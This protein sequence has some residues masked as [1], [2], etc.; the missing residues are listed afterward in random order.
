MPL[1]RHDCP[2]SATI[3]HRLSTLRDYMPMIVYRR[4]RTGETPHMHAGNF[5]VSMALHTGA[6]PIGVD[7]HSHNTTILLAPADDVER[8]RGIFSSEGEEKKEK[9]QPDD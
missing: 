4:V 9:N 6:I 5:W 2:P 7:P 3:V 1:L 8:Q